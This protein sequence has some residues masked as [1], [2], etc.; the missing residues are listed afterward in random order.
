[1]YLNGQQLL[2]CHFFLCVCLLLLLLFFTI[3]L[4]VPIHSEFLWKIAHIS[5]GG[6]LIVSS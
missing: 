6:K 5:K 1:M 3:I 4:T 2:A